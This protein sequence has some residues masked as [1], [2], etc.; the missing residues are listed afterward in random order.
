M[1]ATPTVPKPP[2][3]SPCN[4]CGLCCIDQICPLAGHIFGGAEERRC[5]A[6]EPV[7]DGRFTCGLVV[8]PKHYAPWVKTRERNLRAGALVLIGA[9]LACDGLFEGESKSADWA[10]RV[11]KHLANL[12]EPRLK[13]LAA[14]EV[15]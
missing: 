8:R 13:A 6:L 3:G 2:H 15:K 11:L 7:G 4:G 12:R 14:W 9:N 5:P 10:E 1:H